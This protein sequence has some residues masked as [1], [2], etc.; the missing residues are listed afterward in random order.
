MKM[1]KKKKKI[2]T[3]KKKN[4]IKIIFYFINKLILL[5]Y[6]YLFKFSFN[7]SRYFLAFVIDI[8]NAII[9]KICLF[10]DYFLLEINLDKYDLKYF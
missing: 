1:K 5:Y 7:S 8:N 3:K 2:K 6:I 9:I 4:S 10:L